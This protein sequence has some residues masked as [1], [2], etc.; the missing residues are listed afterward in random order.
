MS[1]DNGI[2][3]TDGEAA[4]I[5]FE[6]HLPHPI[7]AVWAAITEPAQRLAWFGETVLDTEAGRI[8]M[9][10][11]DPPAAADAKRMTG[12][13]LVW[14]PPHVFEHEWHQRIVEDGVV[15]Y[16]LSET[17]TGTLLRFTH[18]GLSVR[19]ARGFIPGT[20]AFFDRL[21]AHLAGAEPP[22]WSERYAALAPSYPA[23]S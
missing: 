11:E 21:D 10:P 8:E 7:E 18:R 15:R 19:N 4:V 3:E 6:R 5:R 9:L 1:T 12:R 22:A 20:H 23:W 16:E 2:I 13:I 14:D 17:A